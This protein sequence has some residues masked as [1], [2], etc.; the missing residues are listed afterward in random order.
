MLSLGVISC[1]YRDKWYIARKLDSLANIFADESIGVSSTTFMQ[2]VAKATEFG[3]ITLWLRQ[4]PRSP[5]LVPIE[6]SYATSY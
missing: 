6:S 2:S 4:S 3:E 5:S 1:Q